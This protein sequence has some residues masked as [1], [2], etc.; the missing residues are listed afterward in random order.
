MGVIELAGKITYVIYKNNDFLVA[1]FETVEGERIKITGNMFGIEEKEKIIVRG[2]WVNHQRFGKQFQV[3][4]WE[5]PIPTTKD[6]VI[7]FLSSGLVKGVGKKRAIDIVNKLGDKA[8]EIINQEGEKALEGIKG[9][10]KKTAQKIAA[11]I[12]ETF[13]VQN[14][15]SQLSVYG[16]STNLI[17]EFYKEYGSESIEKVKENPYRLLKFNGVGFLKADEIARKI[18]FNLTSSHRINACVKYEL[19]ELCYPNGH[20]YIELDILIQKVLSTLNHNVKEEDKVDRDFL[21]QFIHNLEDRVLV[22]DG[23]KVYPKRLFEYEEKVAKKLSIMCNLKSE[24]IPSHEIDRY[25][26]KYQTKNKIILAEKQREAVKRMLQEQVLVLTGNPGTGKTTVVKAIVEIYKEIHPDAIIRLCSPTGRA[27]KKLSEATG[28][29][30]FTLHSTIGFRGYD[31][32]PIYNEDNLLPVSLLIVDEV[33]M[34]DLP[35]AYMMLSA[36]DR[37]TKILLIGDV[38]QL[39]SVGVGNFLSDIIKAGIPTVRLTEI[40]RQASES[41][42]ITNAHR[43]NQ[44]MSL[45][46]DKEKDDFYFIEQHDPVKISNLIIRSVLR[47]IELGYSIENI[48]VLSPMHKGEVGVAVLNEKLRETLNPASSTKNEIKVGNRLFREGDKVI[49]LVNNPDKEVYNGEIG[50]IKTITQEVNADDEEIDVVYCI[51]NNKLIKYYRDE[52]AELDLGFC[53][54]IHKAQGGEAP[55]V[56]MPATM[57]HYRMLTRNLYYTGITRAKEKVVLIGTQ[58]AM[59]R[60]IQNNQVTKRN[61]QLNLRIMQYRQHLNRYIPPNHAKHS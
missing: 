24:T 34:I 18:G 36:L 55:I 3:K 6:G 59:N 20:C 38:D 45:L 26:K 15:I 9:I 22:I 60:A 8:I 53:M 57:N 7:A 25:I 51:F 14:I 43:I 49:Q 21:M 48:L 50:V 42:I 40:F 28:Y 31:V 10:G 27:S 47:F 61:T 16:L 29:P 41:Q 33:S 58:K 35:L 17:L 54:T 52:L 2:E 32:E 46:I 56:I 5:R 37:H 19:N 30:A 39:P 44:G 13:E 11:S 12:K 4:E 23:E 1:W